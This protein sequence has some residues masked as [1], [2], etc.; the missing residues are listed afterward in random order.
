MYRHL[1]RVLALV[2]LLVLLSIL[3]IPTAG[4]NP[5]RLADCAD[6]GFSL[7]EEFVTQGPLPSD[8]N[9]VISDGDLLSSNGAICARN[10]D[11]LAAFGA[12]APLPD[13][14]LD[15]V[16]ILDLESDLVAFST[17]LNRPGGAFTA[18][19]LLTTAGAVIPNAALLASF[20]TVGDLGL[21]SLHFVGPT[22]RILQFLAFAQQ[23]SRES[24]LENPGRLPVELERHEIDLWFSTEGDW[25]PPTGAPGFLDGDLLSA[26][27]G[28]IVYHNGQLLVPPIPAGIPDRGVDFGLDAASA[29]CLGTRLLPDFSTEII[30][31]DKEM[32]VGFTD[33]D[34][35]A[36]GGSVR[37][38]NSDLINAFEPKA[39]M[40]GLD[41]LTTFSER[42]RCEQQ[43]VRAYL[44]LIYRKG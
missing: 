20:N 43:Q 26:A 11:L 42:S 2:L 27:T 15:A 41:A 39:R 37:H 4:Q 5:P 14:G 23:T 32:A 44:P 21:D 30:Y 12:L 9:P 28:T 18:G 33:G 8:G 1:I 40:M 3:P 31:Q 6:I 17:E 25:T 22:Q 16:D 7:E 38:I 10:R 34:V 13:L 36:F 24:W 19:D 29:R 35:L